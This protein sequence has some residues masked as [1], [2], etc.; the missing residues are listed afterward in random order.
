MT[1]SELAQKLRDCY[2]HFEAKAAEGTVVIVPS[3]QSD[4]Y[5][6]YGQVELELQAMGVSAHVQ[7]IMDSGRPWHVV[8]S[9][10]EVGI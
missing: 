6:I 3:V 9:G 7:A 2:W 10:I 4:L 5:R 8:I 1:A